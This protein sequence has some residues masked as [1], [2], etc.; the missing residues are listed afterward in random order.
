MSSHKRNHKKQKHLAL[1]RIQIKI[2][3]LTLGVILVVLYIY[4]EEHIVAFSGLVAHLWV[5]GLPVLEE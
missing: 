4:T 5:M 1:T 3:T 2:V